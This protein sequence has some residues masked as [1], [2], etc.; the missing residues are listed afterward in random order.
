MILVPQIKNSRGGGRR[1]KREAHFVFKHFF[2][3]SAKKTKKKGKKKEIKGAAEDG[4]N[5][6]QE[7]KNTYSLGTYEKYLTKKLKKIP[8]REM[9]PLPT[10]LAAFKKDKQVKSRP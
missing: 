2:R 8:Q 5:V 10:I 7:R 1:E 9:L 4:E 6:I 3:R